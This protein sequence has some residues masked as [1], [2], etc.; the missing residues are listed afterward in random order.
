MRHT[1]I[2]DRSVTGRRGNFSVKNKK[3]QRNT[4]PSDILK[5]AVKRLMLSCAAK[6][7]IMP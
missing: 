7:M 1:P 3:I 6:I 4:I 5:S 2:D